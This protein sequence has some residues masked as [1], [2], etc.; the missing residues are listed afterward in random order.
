MLI[1]TYNI[2]R[3]QG[4]GNTFRGNAFTENIDQSKTKLF[5]GNNF[6]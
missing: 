6:S 4:F 2:F 3:Q 1:L 5:N